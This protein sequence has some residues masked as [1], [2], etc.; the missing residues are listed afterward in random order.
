MRVRNDYVQIKLG[1]KMWTHQNII[2]DEYLKR[3]FNSQIDEVHDDCYIAYCFIKFDTGLNVDYDSTIYPSQFDLKLRNAQYEG[4]F[5][6]KVNLTNN[7]VKINYTFDQNSAYIIGNHWGG[8]E[9]LNNF[10]NRKIVGIGFGVDSSSPIF[11]Y[12]DTSNM[13]IVVNAGE[14]ITITRVDTITSDGICDGIEYPLHLVNDLAF[15]NTST[16]VIGGQ[17]Y[18]KYTKAKLYSVGFGNTKGIMEEEYIVNNNIIKDRTNNSITFN[19]N[20]N[21]NIGIYPSNNLNTGFIPIKDNSKYIIFRYKLYEIAETG[22][23]FNL[24]EYYTMSALNE[25]F[26]DLDIKLKIERL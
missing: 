12:L 2:L 14:Y 21:K 15:R 13:N 25:D 23:T 17:T 1:N 4:N 22:D 10:I 5:L 7:S 8:T 20:R 16:V 3:L 9:L 26:G 11:A 18:L 24:N 19:I 6:K